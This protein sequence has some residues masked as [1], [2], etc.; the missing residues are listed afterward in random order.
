MK[1][2]K[3][4]PVL[5]NQNHIYLL[6]EIKR[7]PTILDAKV[8]DSLEYIRSDET[9][10]PGNVLIGHAN[11]WLFKLSAE[12]L[13]SDYIKLFTIL[14]RQNLSARQFSGEMIV[15]LMSSTESIRRNFHSIQLVSN[16][17]WIKQNQIQVNQFF[18]HRWPSYP[19]ETKFEIMKLLSKHV[20]TVNDLIIDQQAEEILKR[21]TMNTLVAVTGMI[22]NESIRYV[23]FFLHRSYC[24]I[25][26]SMVSHDV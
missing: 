7:A 15:H 9:R 18:Q 12:D 11:A 6:L 16:D 19:F 23:F 3:I 4:T 13:R 26:S 21:C 2:R 22:A 24:S 25:S 17:E 1:G 5:I 20:I 8:T 14:S 10:L